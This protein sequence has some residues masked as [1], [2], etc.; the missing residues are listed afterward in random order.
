M[1]Y[2]RFIKTIDDGEVT[3]LIDD[4]VASDANKLWRQR[5]VN[6]GRF[7]SKRV[8]LCISTEIDGGIRDTL[9]LAVCAN[10]IIESKS[11]RLP[12]MRIARRLTERER[13]LQKQQLEVLGYVD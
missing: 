12:R 4:T 9:A 8:S 13:K 7:D 5:R 2:I 11:Q 3:T 1:E 10:P 6:L